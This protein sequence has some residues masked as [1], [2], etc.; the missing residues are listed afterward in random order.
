MESE[1]TL[2]KLDATGVEWGTPPWPLAIEVAQLL[3]ASSWTLVGGL[4]VRLRAIISDLPPSRNT[5]DVDATLHLD[6]GTTSFGDTAAKLRGAGFILDPSTAFAYRFARSGEVVEDVVDVM[7]SDVYSRTRSPRFDQRP[8]FGVAGARRALD[9]TETVELGC[10]NGVTTVFSVPSV[11]GALVLKGA[12]YLAD[13]RDKGRHLSDGFMLVA[14]VE[15]PLTVRS[16]LSARSRKRVRSLLRG[17]DQNSLLRY[18]HDPLVR[19]LAADNLAV[20][21]AQFDIYGD[22]NSA[23]PA[24]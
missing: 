6:T 8:L 2:H 14:C 19:D 18:E 9:Q 12:A 17:I 11:T 16:S 22:D 21:N 1:R 13:Q 3:P 23:G 7:C 5:T 24:V 10:P 20:L 15:D 4:M